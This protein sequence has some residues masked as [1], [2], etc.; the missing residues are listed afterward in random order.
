MR[1]PENQDDAVSSRFGS[2][3]IAI[4]AIANFALFPTVAASDTNEQIETAGD[5]FQ[6]AI[7]LAALGLTY[8]KDDKEGRKQFAK[9]GGTTFLT[10]HALKAAVDKWRPNYSDENSFPSGHTAAA[11]TGAAFLQTRYG[12]RYG[13]PGYLLAAFVGYSRIRAENHYSDDV[14]AG[15]SIAMLSNWLFATPLDNGVTMAPTFGADRVGLSVTVPTRVTRNHNPEKSEPFTPKYR[16]AFSFG[17][18]SLDNNDV[19]APGATGSMLNLETFDAYSSP[20]T[21]S[22]VTFEYFHSDRH[23][24]YAVLNPLEVRDQGT[25]TTP[26][27]FAGSVYPSGT[28]TNMDY[29]M[30]EIRGGYLY[31]LIPNGRFDLKLG[32]G[33]ALQNTS[34]RLISDTLDNTVKSFDM[35]PYLS[36]QANFD[37]TDRLQFQVFVDG[38]SFDSLEFVDAVAS[39]RYQLTQKW[40]IGF[41]VQNYSRKVDVSE[42]TNRY[43]G[44]STFLTIGH[45]F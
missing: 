30:N 9:S 11:F 43:E 23:E 33:I 3:L 10:V 1:S 31:N 40:D 27:R 28:L 18:T 8:A 13:V 24:F 26:E 25:F 5:F 29:V 6:I 45:T 21:S 36:V 37:L 35:A 17:A 42:L 38:T 41:G 12:S 32:G 15:A 16:F 39:L 7:P 20:T 14:L 22:G 2:T 44:N 4:A 19:T 34:V